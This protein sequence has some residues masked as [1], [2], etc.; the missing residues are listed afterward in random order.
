MQFIK[1]E[2]EQMRSLR[3]EVDRLK[4]CAADM[5][6]LHLKIDSLAAAIQD[7]RSQSLSEVQHLQDRV[8]TP[9]AT[10]SSVPLGSAFQSLSA[11]TG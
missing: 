3:A 11:G 10:S 1:T 6:D 4:S 7:L 5:A 8:A 9:E 2:L